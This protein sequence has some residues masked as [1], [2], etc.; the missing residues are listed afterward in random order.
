MFEELLKFKY[1]CKTIIYYYLL[2]GIDRIKYPPKTT[3]ANFVI[4]IF[5]FFSRT[6]I[7]KISLICA[8]SMNVLFGSAVTFTAILLTYYKFI[9]TYNVFFL[10]DFRALQWKNNK[11]IKSHYRNS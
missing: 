2:L 11:I 3:I 8:E 7:S 6:Y 5:P 1:S 10:S 4:V 9:F